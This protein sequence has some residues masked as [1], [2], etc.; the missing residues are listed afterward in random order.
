MSPVVEVQVVLPSGTVPRIGSGLIVTAPVTPSTATSKFRVVEPVATW[1]ASVVFD[2]RRDKLTVEATE[3]APGLTTPA[4]TPAA[5]RSEL[6][7]T[8][9]LVPVRSVVAPS[10]MEFG[11]LVPETSSAN[12]DQELVTGLKQPAAWLALPAPATPAVVGIRNRTVDEMSAKT[13]NAKC[14][15]RRGRMELPPGDWMNVARAN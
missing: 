9:R 5:T 7:V 1:V 3:F 14:A 2:A 4:P 12:D 13:M 11:E 6:T 15:E 8:T 10:L